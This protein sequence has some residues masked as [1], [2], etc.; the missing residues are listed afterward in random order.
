[1]NLFICPI[2]WHAR[3][4]FLDQEGS[5]PSP[6]QWKCRVLT[7]ERPGKS[8]IFDTIFN[9]I[10]YLQNIDYITHRTSLLAQSVKN[11]PAVEETRAQSLGQEDLLGKEMATHSNILAWKILWTEGAWWAPVLGVTRVRHD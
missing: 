6:L 1:M 9:A 3:S 11:L 2:G 7:S 10:F 8:P 4:W 5:I